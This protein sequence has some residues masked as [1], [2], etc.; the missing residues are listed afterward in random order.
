MEHRLNFLFV[1]ENKWLL[2]FYDKH[3][4]S[5]LCI[6]LRKWGTTLPEKIVNQ[7]YKTVNEK[8]QLK[9]KAI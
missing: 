1:N 4:I 6:D 2:S 8:D 7:F 5:I 3:K 9:L